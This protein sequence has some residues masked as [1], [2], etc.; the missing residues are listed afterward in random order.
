MSGVHTEQG[1]EG[2]CWGQWDRPQELRGDQALGNRTDGLEQLSQHAECRWPQATAQ[3][4]TGT[5]DPWAG[6]VCAAGL[7][8]LEGGKGRSGQGLGRMR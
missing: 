7:N 1:S 2:G 4:S 3:L 6:H 8:T 5:R